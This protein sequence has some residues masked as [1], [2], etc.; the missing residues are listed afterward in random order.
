[1]IFSSYILS[2]DDGRVIGHEQVIKVKRCQRCIVFMVLLKGKRDSE[3]DLLPLVEIL[4]RLRV[5]VCIVA[6][7]C[8]DSR[9]YSEITNNIYIGC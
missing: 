1:M 8:Y 7:L 6:I 4:K 3:S 2:K 9:K 5:R